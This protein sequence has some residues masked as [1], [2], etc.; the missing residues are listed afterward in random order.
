MDAHFQRLSLILTVIS[1]TV[2]QAPRP[3][4]ADGA[5]DYYRAIRKAGNVDAKTREKIKAETLDA[6]RIREANALANENNDHTRKLDAIK[7]EKPS[8]QMIQEMKNYEKG[9]PPPKPSGTPTPEQLKKQ[10]EYFANMEKLKTQRKTPATKPQKSKP[11]Q[12]GPESTT[13]SST[14]I[15]VDSNLPDEIDFTDETKKA[16]TQ[17]VPAPSQK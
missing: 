7:P 5:D 1:I 14:A 13:T 10:E 12:K 17:K 6:A 4:H 2:A 8:A 16:D 15:K 3:A 11:D 9:L